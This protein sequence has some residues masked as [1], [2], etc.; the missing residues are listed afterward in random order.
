MNNSIQ[1]PP[2]YPGEP[3]PLNGDTYLYLPTQVEYVCQRESMQS[4]PIW[5][6]KGVMDSS[7][8]AYQGIVFLTDLAPINAQT[9]YIY[10][11]GADVSKENIDP[12]WNGLYNVSDVLQ[13]QLIIFSDPL[14]VKVK[15]GISPFVRTNAGEI[16]PLQD[17]DD[18][19]M[20][21]GEYRIDVLD[22]LP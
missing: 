5:N 10:S 11:V 18:L 4:T 6:A 19:N 17:G 2:I 7:A 15:I 8:F 9:G 16:V 22:E 14:W 13:W 20:L 12:S 3:E 1:F 21:S